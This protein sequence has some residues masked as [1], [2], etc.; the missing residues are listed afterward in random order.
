VTCVHTV[1][2]FMTYHWLCNKSNT[3][4]AKCGAETFNSSRAPVFTWNCTVLL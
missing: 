4:G 3:T 2:S 1:D